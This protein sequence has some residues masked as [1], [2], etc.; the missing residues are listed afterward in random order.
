MIDKPN[1]DYLIKIF[2]SFLLH[3]FVKYKQRYGAIIMKLNDKA[4][5][6][7]TIKPFIDYFSLICILFS[8][9][10]SIGII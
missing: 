8:A 9:S 3:Y 10:Y 1:Y 2:Y 6:A 4:F 5:N 7:E